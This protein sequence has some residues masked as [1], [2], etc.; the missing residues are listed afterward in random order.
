MRSRII[1]FERVG[2]IIG[3]FVISSLVYRFH[4]MLKLFLFDVQ[5]LYV[6]PTGSAPS[7]IYLLSTQRH[8]HTHKRTSGLLNSNFRIIEPDGLLSVGRPFLETFNINR[9]CDLILQNATQRNVSNQKREIR[10][11]QRNTN[12][13]GIRLSTAEHEHLKERAQIYL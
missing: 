8:S 11:K 2:W 9:I 4:F 7:L 6:S 1:K 5:L 12:L 13:S 3:L 10:L